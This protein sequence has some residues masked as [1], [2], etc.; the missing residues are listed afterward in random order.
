MSRFLPA[1]HAKGDETT[2]GGYE[3]VHQR[4]ASFD[5]ADGFAYTVAVLTDELADDPRG[6]FAAYFLFLRWRR[7]GEE[8]VEGHV[9][10]DYLEFASLRA[11]A[12]AALGAWPV[13]RAEEYLRT[14]LA[15]ELAD[16]TAHGM[17]DHGDAANE[18]AAAGDAGEA[19]A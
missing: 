15:L 1:D 17:S 9:E 13:A 10:S 14:V 12:A 18:D 2:V 19:G 3:A 6:R 7:L 4:A 5:A 16:E 8:G 11:A